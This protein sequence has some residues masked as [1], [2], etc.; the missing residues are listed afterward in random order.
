MESLTYLHAVTVLIGAGLAAIAIRAPRPM[1][2]RVGAIVLAGFLM[3][4]AYAGY[5]ELLGRPKPTNFEWAARNVSEAVVLAA[6]MREGEAIYLWL[7]LDEN[8]EPRA[9]TLPW[10]L[11]AAR[12][13]HRA[14]AQAE[15]RGTAV[16]VRGPFLEGHLD[17]ERMFYA[18]PQQPLPPKMARIGQAPIR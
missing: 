6:E 3:V 17:G 16:R 7:Q 15:Q 4:S 1:L 11:Q 13:L 10:S 12:Q 2:M 8:P 9:Y 14:R 5:A 18:D